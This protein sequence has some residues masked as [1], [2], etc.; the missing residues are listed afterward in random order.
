MSAAQVTHTPEPKFV[1]RN[2]TASTD[3]RY[4]SANISDSFLVALSDAKR[5]ASQ[6]AAEKFLA[7]NSE[8]AGF[9]TEQVSP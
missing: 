8:F 3:A 2:C 7:N 4:L 9:R 6:K 1:L 5:F